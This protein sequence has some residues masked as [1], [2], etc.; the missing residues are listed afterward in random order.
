[1]VQYSVVTEVTVVDWHRSQSPRVVVVWVIVTVEAGQVEVLG[2]VELCGHS[3]CSPP[4][5]TCGANCGE[6]EFEYG[7]VW[8]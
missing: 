5:S 1:M 4:F 8:P 7:V 6:V 3:Y 2:G